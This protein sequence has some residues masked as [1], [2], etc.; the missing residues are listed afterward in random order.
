MEKREIINILIRI[1]D[2]IELENNYKDHVHEDM[3]IKLI[4][5]TVEKLK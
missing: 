3:A 2:F 1:K 4:D 5:K